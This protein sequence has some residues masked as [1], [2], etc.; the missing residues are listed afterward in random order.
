MTQNSQNSQLNIP[1]VN[2]SDI[3][4]FLD[5]M[6]NQP[7]DYIDGEF[8]YDVKGYYKRLRQHEMFNYWLKYVH[9]R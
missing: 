2:V 7:K 5:W 8:F 1:N 6:N 4:S 3:H 9:S